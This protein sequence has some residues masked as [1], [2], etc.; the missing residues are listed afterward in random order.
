[1]KHWLLLQVRG[2]VP[3]L[4]QPSSVPSQSNV[5]RVVKQ[6]VPFSCSIHVDAS[7]IRPRFHTLNRTVGRAER[8]RWENG[9]AAS[10][11]DGRR[12]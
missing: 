9:H 5:T 8:P 11:R 3:S 6:H 7:G 1:M 2:D 4:R 10:T 12:T